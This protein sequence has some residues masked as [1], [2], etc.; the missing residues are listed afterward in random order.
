VGTGGKVTLTFGPQ[1]LAGSE[2]GTSLATIS[3]RPV[4]DTG[5]GGATAESFF[6]PPGSVASQCEVWGGELIVRRMN[7]IKRWE[8][9]LTT[10]MVSEA[11]R[12]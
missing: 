6:P 7:Q 11:E 2:G 3:T 8:D 10:L 1:R 9:T 5:T 12:C 4:V